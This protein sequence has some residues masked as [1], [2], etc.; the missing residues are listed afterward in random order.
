[1]AFRA[2][3]LSLLQVQRL[4]LRHSS[5]RGG[6]GACAVDPSRDVLA[7]LSVAL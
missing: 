6:F 4:L 7:C 5:L 1:M 3:L 2:H